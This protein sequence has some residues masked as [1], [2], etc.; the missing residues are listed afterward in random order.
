MLR[1]SVVKQRRSAVALALC[2]VG[3]G[4]A[5]ARTAAARDAAPDCSP[6][7]WFCDDKPST[8]PELAPPPEVP[9]SAPETGQP[10]GNEPPP[11][12]APP[13]GMLPERMN[14]T[15]PMSER[16]MADEDEGLQ[17]RWSV[18]LR[19]QGIALEASPHH[20]DTGLGGLGASLRYAPLPNLALDLGFDSF[21]GSD[22]NGY[23][24]TENSASLSALLYLNP[25]RAI[26]TYLLGGFN[27]SA[28]HVDVAGDGQNWNYVGAQAGLGL[29]FVVSRSVSLNVDMLGFIRGRTDSRA[30]HE[31]EFNDGHGNLTNTSGGGL[32]RGGVSL[33]W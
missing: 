15:P 25:R 32:F 28:A 26:R 12:A 7:D 23:D 10:D 20:R 19:L 27:V 16:G 18:N 4:V 31:P 1:C 2:V 3:A 14:L 24:R 29:D 13:P 21:G 17:G 22:Y 30:A 8:P 6:D 5:G 11:P 9:Q 33:Y